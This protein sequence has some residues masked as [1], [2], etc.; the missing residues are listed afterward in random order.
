MKLSELAKSVGA[1]IHGDHNTVVT[2]VAS[3]E[4]AQ[5][6]QLSFLVGAQYRHQLKNTQ[7]S[8][9]VLSHSDLEQCPCDAIVTD[10][11]ELAFA[12]MLDFFNKGATIEPGIHLSAVI[13]NDCDIDASVTISAHCVIGND[14]KIGANTIVSSGVHIGDG[15]QI[16]A[17]C[18]LY[19]HVTLY[20]DVLIADRVVIHS[21][22]VIGADGFGYTNDDQGRWVKIRQ[23]GTVCLASDV[24]IG[25]N[26]TIDRG[27]LENTIIEEGVKIDNQVQVAHNVHIGAHT[28]IAGCVGIA[29]S[30]RIGKHCMIGGGV[31]INGHITIADSVIVTGMAMVMHSI[32]A[33]GVYSSGTGLQKNLQWRKSAIRFQQ[34]DGMAKRIKHLERLYNE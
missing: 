9:V 25:A 24:E 5:H 3:L 29:G 20:H 28:A 11:P 6:G 13:G 17:N 10:N 21:G 7:A 4:V 22:A 8:A 1:E 18:H 19:P 32:D 16:G 33:S 27:A 31:C 26:T 23:V 12:K 2:G 14:V 34:L 15:V 30:A